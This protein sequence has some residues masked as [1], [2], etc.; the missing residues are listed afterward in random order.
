[1]LLNGLFSMS[2]LAVVSSRKPR[3]RLRAER[4]DK[5]AAA[6]LKLLD[7]PN[8]FLSAVQ[9]GITLIGILSGAY[10]Q[11]TIA[12]ELDKLLETASPALA[13]YSEVIATTI[14]VVL[15]TY[16]S[17]VAG[18]L[19]PKRF[20]MLFPEAIASRMAAPLAAMARLMG[21]FV[22]LLTAST[23]G[24]LKLLRIRDDR[25]STM[26]QEEVDTVLA[27]GTSAGVIEPQEQ[28]MM[29]EVMRLGD[30]PVRVAMTPRR[31][32]FWVSL[33]EPE[34]ELRQEV[35]D[36]PYSRMVVM[37]GS[38][39]ESPIGVVHKGDVLNALLDHGRLDLTP[40]I[41]T[42]LFI[43]QTAPL[44]RVI[45]MFK[46]QS[47]HMALIVDEL[48]VFTGIVTATDILEM[49]AGNFHEAHDEDLGE[50]IVR[51][52]DGSMLVD[53]RTD[54]VELGH[55]L[56]ETF[57]DHKGFH[58]AAGLVLHHLGRIPSEGEVVRI[59]RFQVEV[60]DMDERRIDKLLFHRSAQP[61]STS[62]E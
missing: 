6:A 7:N 38:D 46:Q 59:G 28:A 40:L 24:V 12:A 35:R 23:A 33:T 25:G 20:A 1:M 31:E 51:R 5:G 27:E 61:D 50:D 53:G 52:A 2:E 32:V 16:L 62:K 39:A 34:P 17:L 56:G 8:R 13:P 48:G 11:A 4:G 57:D 21:P 19:V 47:V 18:E 45:E 36:C 10:G 22:T 37:S 60:V 41:R 26:T 43:P 3:L 9:V 58:T 44:L 55:A 49:I 14:V 42:P 29:A 30:R 15:I 54:L